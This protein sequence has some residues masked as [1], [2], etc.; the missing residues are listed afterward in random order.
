[1]SDTDV[2]DFLAHYG[3]LGMQWGKRK[4]KQPSVK[5]LSRKEVKA[6]KAAFYQ[7]KGS[8][9]VEQ[10]LKHPKNLIELHSGAGY[11]TIVTGKEF[12]T[13]LSAG[14]L[15]NI[16]RTDIY[17]TRKGKGPYI[18]NPNPNATYQKPR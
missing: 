11:P 10:A 3:V 8:R 6:D 16:E 9:L 18:L 2:K 15:L 5:K 17:A 1:M 12:I 4:A 14:G 13:H 7:A